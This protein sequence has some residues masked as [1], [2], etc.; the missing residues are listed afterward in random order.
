[1][2]ILYSGE[3]ATSWQA[4]DESPKPRHKNS[5]HTFLDAWPFLVGDELLRFVSCAFWSL[6]STTVSIII[7]YQWKPS[8]FTYPVLKWKHSIRFSRICVW[9]PNVCINFINRWELRHLPPST[10][11]FHSQP[12]VSRWSSSPPDSSDKR[13]IP[14]DLLRR[15]SQ[16]CSTDQCESG[17]M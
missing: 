8:C 17:D 5:R 12:F 14:P 10:V 1:M 9:E 11:D 16:M 15:C 6:I 3:V 2:R 7:R 13:S 4:C